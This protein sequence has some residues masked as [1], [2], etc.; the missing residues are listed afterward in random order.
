MTLIC[1]VSTVG[2]ATFSRTLF[3]TEFMLQVFTVIDFVWNFALPVT[4]FVFCYMRIFYVIRRH[5]KVASSDQVNSSQNITM[6]T[7]PHNQNAGQVQ[8]HA[9]G[10]TT[11]DMLSRTELNVLQTMTAIIAC[12]IICWAPASLGNI[13]ELTVWLHLYARVQISI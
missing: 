3:I 9:N 1:K 5:N 10:A 7:L 6:A 4:I 11:S 12:F 13:I 8:Q 2:G